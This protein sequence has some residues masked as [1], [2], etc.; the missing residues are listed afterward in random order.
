MTPTRPP[1]LQSARQMAS[2]INS[3]IVRKAAGQPLAAAYEARNA[4][5]TSL[6]EVLLLHMYERTAKQLYEEWQECEI[7]IGKRPQRGV[8]VSE[9]RI[10][11]PLVAMPAGG[12]Q[13]LLFHH[14]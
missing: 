6:P 10:D 13:E 9:L 1:D 3:T 7:I 2:G 8:L 5:I 12:R 4:F 11:Q 14:V